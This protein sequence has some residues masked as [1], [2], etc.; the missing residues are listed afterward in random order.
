MPFQ[1]CGSQKIYFEKNLFFFFF[2][3]IIVLYFFIVL[4]SKQWVK[5]FGPHWQ[6]QMKRSS[7]LAKKKKSNSD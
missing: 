6:K 4:L 3:N 2:M 1:T 5:G 7:N